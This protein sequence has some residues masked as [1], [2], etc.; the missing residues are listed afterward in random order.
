MSITEGCTVQHRTKNKIRGTVLEISGGRAYL[1]LS[2]GVEDDYPLSELENVEDIIAA[3]ELAAKNEEHERNAK[4]QR[5]DEIWAAMAV[6]DFQKVIT[7]LYAMM[8]F[9]EVEFETLSNFQ[10]MSFIEILLQ[11]K[12]E[13]LIASMETGPAKFRLFVIRLLSNPTVTAICAA[14]GLRV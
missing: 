2:N 13:H 6:A 3:K 8:P 14:N 9:T 1:E 12:Y 5:F 4:L 7:N 11:T 10:K